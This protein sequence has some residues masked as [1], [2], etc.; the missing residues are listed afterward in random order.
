MG[1][2]PLEPSR[3]PED[4]AGGFGVCN[5]TTGYPIQGTQWLEINK[6]LKDISRIELHYLV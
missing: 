1:W 2:N 4:L 6:D 5:Y 3:V